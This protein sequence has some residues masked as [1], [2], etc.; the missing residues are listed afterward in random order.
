MQHIRNYREPSA[1]QI[2]LYS[3]LHFTSTF[4]LFLNLKHNCTLLYKVKVVTFFYLTLV[5]SKQQVYAKIIDVKI[6]A[7]V[8]YSIT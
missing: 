6:C 7:D 4:N 1:V 8:L 5:L 3:V 2:A